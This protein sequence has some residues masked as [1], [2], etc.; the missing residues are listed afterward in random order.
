MTSGCVHDK[1]MIACSST[2]LTQYFSKFTHDLGLRSS[3]INLY[4]NK[5][6]FNKVLTNI[7]RKFQVSC[8]L[9]K[10]IMFLRN[11]ERLS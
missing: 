5:P 8:I 1:W 9:I 10:S 7:L 2:Y 4:E 6:P 3:L 11:F